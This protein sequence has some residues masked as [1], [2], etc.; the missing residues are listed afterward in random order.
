MG[1]PRTIH[2]IVAVGRK[3]AGIV[4]LAVDLSGRNDLWFRNYDPCG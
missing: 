1:L 4:R 3:L 2:V